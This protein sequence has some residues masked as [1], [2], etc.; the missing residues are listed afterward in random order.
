MGKDTLSTL[1]KKTGGN[2]QDLGGLV[3]R[4]AAAA[5]PLEGKLQGAGHDA[6]IAFK[7]R[8]DSIAN[9]LNAGLAAI[10]K[11]QSGMDA[12]T[13][14][15]ES[16]MAQAAKKAEGAANFDGAKFTKR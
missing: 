7:G 14:T 3:K 9:D 4:L 11:G 8:V 12:A 2:T 16:D 10:A 6:F 15:G 5:Q 13:R 1:A